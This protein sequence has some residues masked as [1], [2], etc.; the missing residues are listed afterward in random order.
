MQIGTQLCAYDIIANLAKAEWARSFEPATRSADAGRDQTL[1]ESVESAPGV[2]DAMKR[3]L[4]GPL[5][6]RR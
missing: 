3:A 1:P 2:S 6:D 4:R 5:F